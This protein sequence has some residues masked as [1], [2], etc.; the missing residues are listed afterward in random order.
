[1]NNQSE[2][3][4]LDRNKFPNLVIV[5]ATASGKT[6]VA[7]QLSKVLG[8]GLIDIDQRIVAKAGRS[9]P[10]IFAQDGVNRFRE[11]E[12]EILFSLKGILNHVIVAGA[13][14][15]ESEEN[16]DHLRQLGPSIWLATPISEI[17]HRLIKFP[18]ELAK[19]PF[20]AEALNITSI[21]EREEFL[22][23]RLQDLED[24]RI[25]KYSQSDYRVTIGFATADTCAQ[26]I[27][28]LLIQP[29]VS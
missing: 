25:T 4:T 5:G 1:M 3:Q 8:F 29:E 23:K 15:I 2:N 11:I 24:Q 19:R 20:L 26:F 16:W 22:V 7:Y 12:S 28:Q 9:I 10:E 13:G 27:K 17:V 21:K 18:E 14:A 6:T